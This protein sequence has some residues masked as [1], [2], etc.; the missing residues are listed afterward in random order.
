MKKTHCKRGHL[1]SGQ[2]AARDSR[3]RRFCLT[4]RKH[5]LI[6]RKNSHCKRGHALSGFNLIITK[7]GDRRCRTCSL[8][9]KR[10]NYVKK[11]PTQK[12][13]CRRGHPFSLENTRIRKSGKRLCKTCEAQTGRTYREAHRDMFSKSNRQ[14][15]IN[16]LVNQQPRELRGPSRA[17]YELRSLVTKKFATE[18]HE[19][20]GIK[21]TVTE[22]ADEYK[23]KERSLLWRIKNGYSMTDAILQGNYRGRLIEV[24]GQKRTLRNFADLFEIKSSVVIM[25]INNH[26]YDLE[27]AF[28]WPLLK[29][30]QRTHCNRG[31]PHTP[32]NTRGYYTDRRI[33]RICIRLNQSKVKQ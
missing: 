15:R 4:C 2:H 29:R 13:H 32:E 6:C 23:I 19:A 27:R 24:F 10:R 11:R 33:C 14:C 30:K 5:P 9:S 8:Y 12:T 26:G 28:L 1:L 7:K 3:G 16:R 17:L 18:I 22:W 21:K 20:F 25:R 31:H